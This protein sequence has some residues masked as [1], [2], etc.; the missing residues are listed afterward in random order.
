MRV[1]TLRLHNPTEFQKNLLMVEECTASSWTDVFDD[2]DK[3]NAEIARLK[4][5]RQDQAQVYFKKWIDAEE[6]LD[7][8]Y[9]KNSGLEFQNKRMS[10]IL[11]VCAETAETTNSLMTLISEQ[12]DEA[13]KE[14]DQLKSAG[15]Q[16]MR[17]IDFTSGVSL[18]FAVKEWK[19]ALRYEQ[20]KALDEL[21]TESQRLG[22]YPEMEMRAFKESIKD[23]EENWRHGLI[24]ECAEP[25]QVTYPDNEVVKSS[26]YCKKCLHVI[27][28]DKLIDDKAKK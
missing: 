2:L 21:T 27:P 26:T 1:L 4:D 8:Q 14:V 17:A 9:V 25:V 15:N 6:A 11:K 18:D 13:L 19:N 7:K 3:A 10:D 24:C 12:R 5:L 23:Y 20:E 16:M 28:A 22:L